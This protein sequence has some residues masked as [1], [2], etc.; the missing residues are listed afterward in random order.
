MKMPVRGRQ[1][2]GKPLNKHRGTYSQQKDTSIVSEIEDAPHSHGVSSHFCR[3]RSRRMLKSQSFGG[4]P[5]MCSVLWLGFPHAVL[6]TSVWGFFFFS[7]DESSA[8]HSRAVLQLVERS[9]CKSPSLR[10]GGVLLA[11]SD[12]ACR[13]YTWKTNKHGRRH[14]NKTVEQ[15]F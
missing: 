1:H 10:G 11:S 14:N 8:A 7:Q 15:T 5:G 12:S 9:G 3:E 6:I 2:C 4:K 13:L